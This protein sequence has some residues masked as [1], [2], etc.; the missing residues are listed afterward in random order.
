MSS[1]QRFQIWIEQRNHSQKSKVYTICATNQSYHCVSKCKSYDATIFEVLK[2]VFVWKSIQNVSCRKQHASTIRQ[3]HEWFLAIFKWSLARNV[4]CETS[5]PNSTKKSYFETLLLPA[6]VSVAM[7]QRILVNSGGSSGG[8]IWGN[9]PPKRMWRPLERHPFAI[10]AH[11][12]GAHGNRNRDK[13]YSKINNFGTAI[14]WGLPPYAAYPGAA[15]GLPH[16]FPY[17]VRS[18]EFLLHE[19]WG[20]VSFLNVSCEV[21][22][23]AHRKG[24]KWST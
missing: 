20:P 14:A 23:H 2:D 16:Q 13:K 10:N 7:Y 4:A 3:T 21:Y 8:T 19:V 9:C 17:G 15:W 5:L 11:L 1:T 24:S 6:W 22:R 12:F 18:G